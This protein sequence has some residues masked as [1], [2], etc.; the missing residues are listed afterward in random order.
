[1]FL[2]LSRLKTEVH[3]H[4]QEQNIT[5]LRQLTPDQLEKIVIKDSIHFPIYNTM[6]NQ[7]ETK[8]SKVFNDPIH[9]HMALH[10]V[11][12]KI[13]DTPEFQ[14]LRNIRQLGGIYNVYPG[15]S[16]NRFEHSIGVAHLAGELAKALKMK[17]EKQ[18][19]QL[20]E[21]KELKE[22]KKLKPLELE[23][24]KK[25]QNLTPQD[26]MELQELMPE[27]LEKLKKLQNSKPEDLEK[28]KAEELEDL[29][30]GR[31]GEPWFYE[32]EK[33]KKLQNSKS[34]GLEKLNP[35]DLKMLQRF[36]PK[37]VEKFEKLERLDE[38]KKSLISDRDVLCVEIA[39]LC[40]DLG[41]GPYSHFYDG[42]FMDAIKRDKKGKADKEVT[43]NEKWTHEKA[44][45]EMFKHL[46]VQNGLKEVMK[47][48][49]LKVDE[50]G[51]DLEFIEEMI[52][53]PQDKKPQN[54]AAQDNEH[55][56]NDASKEWLYKGRE[57]K[58]SFLY[59]IVSN[60]ETGIDVDKFDYVARDC[61][62]LGIPNS[63]DHQRFIM[64][65]RVCDVEED[66]KKT[67]H[68]CSRDKESANLYDIFQ[69]RL[70]IHR[71]AC[72]HKIKMAVEI[73]IKD[74][75][76]LADKDPYIQIEIS[77]GNGTSKKVPLSKAK[78]KM[79]AYMKLTDQVIERILNSSSDSLKEA[80]EILHR[81]M[82]RDLYRCVGQARKKEEPKM[83]GEMR[84]S[85][86]KMVKGILEGGEGE[87]EVIVVPLDS[88]KEDISKAFFYRKDNPNKAIPIAEPEVKKKHKQEKL[89]M[90]ESLKKLVKDIPEG[91]EDEFVIIV[92]PLD[93]EKEDNDPVSQAFFYRKDNPN[94]KIPITKSEESG[95]RI[96][97]RERGE[98][99]AGELEKEYK[100]KKLEEMKKDL[101]DKLSK[102]FREDKF[103]VINV[104]LD[105]GMED[106]DPISKAF[107][108]RKDKPDKA[109]PISKSKVSKLLPEHFSDEILRVY[110]KNHEG[111]Q[112]K[113]RKNKEKEIKK[114]FKTQCKDYGFETQNA[115]E[116]GDNDS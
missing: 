37:D 107:F 114:F 105:Y 26:L 49:G 4:C 47:K 15:A 84:E 36:K 99:S 41:H 53:K 70:S 35:E 90:R 80:R 109:I 73:M 16:H 98:T 39:G 112:E 9:G 106:N 72:Q 58:K 71:R 77:N 20:E 51:T 59:E 81:V 65:A 42:M 31:V 110:W 1:M 93:S 108:Y 55:Q 12:V 83:S 67:K 43:D 79:E 8:E 87:F 22:L 7:R 13:I 27:D 96:T 103:E 113:E 95:Q 63:F 11:L 85:L 48:Y 61:Q 88:E 30:I 29:E 57:E 56:N 94:K 33:L 25:L 60:K 28:L 18:I 38:L 69:Q 17:Q 34:E 101:K 91:G 46:L 19:E 104:T 23:Q 24:L 76:L 32:L 75:L 102:R 52:E 62:Q 21:L 78:D 100:K 2:V 50:D 82:T 14:R 115:E 89:E 86:N 10:P 54:D 68:I 92:V 111:L 116:D 3:S 45:I 64:L 6:E 5:D 40:H 44:S 74:A 97:K 66:R